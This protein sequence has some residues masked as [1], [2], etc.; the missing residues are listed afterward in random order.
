[1]RMLK[2]FPWVGNFHEFNSYELLSGLRNHRNHRVDLNSYVQVEPCLEKGKYLEIGEIPPELTET[3]KVDSDQNMISDSWVRWGWISIILQRPD[4]VMEKSLTIDSAPTM[5]DVETF[6][7]QVL[8]Q[9]QHF[10]FEEIAQNGFLK[11]THIFLKV[12]LELN[13]RLIETLGHRPIDSLYLEEQNKLQAYFIHLIKSS[14]KVLSSDSKNNQEIDSGKPRF[15]QGLIFKAIDCSSIEKVYLPYPQADVEV[16]RQD[17]IMT[18]AAAKMLACYYYQNNYM[19]WKNLFHDEDS[20]FRSFEKIERRLDLTTSYER[21][22]RDSFPIM[23]EARLFPWANPFI[24][25]SQ[26][27][28]VTGL[29]FRAGHY[30]RGAAKNVSKTTSRGKKVRGEH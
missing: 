13:K 18:E 12:L 25:T 10:A 22:Y 29:I 11:R 26:Q 9:N 3:G 16:S 1:M 17:V 8:G 5:L 7:M 24:I 23:Q 6:R 21:F 4:T 15:I 2:L 14:P 30:A 28:R 19:K 27:S 20:F